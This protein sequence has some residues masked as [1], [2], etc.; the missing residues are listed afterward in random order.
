MWPK[1]YLYE[2]IHTYTLAVSKTISSVLLDPAS[3]AILT[4]KS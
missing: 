1:E 3:T 4:A 2:G